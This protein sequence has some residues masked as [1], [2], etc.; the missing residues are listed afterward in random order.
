[1]TSCV[2]NVSD[3]VIDAVRPGLAMT[4]QH[5]ASVQA[6]KASEGIERLCSI[7]REGRDLWAARGE[8]GTSSVAPSPKVLTSATFFVLRAP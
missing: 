2:T 8:P 7:R 1:V 4:G 5:E 3:V 6:H